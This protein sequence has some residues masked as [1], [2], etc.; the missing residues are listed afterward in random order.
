MNFSEK[1]KQNLFKATVMHV[2]SPDAVYELSGVCGGPVY[3]QLPLQPNSKQLLIDASQEGPDNIY[4]LPREHQDPLASVQCWRKV[5]QA[6]I[7]NDMPVAD[8]EKKIVEQDQRDRSKLRAEAGTLDR[9]LYFAKGP[10]DGWEFASDRSVAAYLQNPAEYLWPR[11]SGPGVP[12]PSAAPPAQASSSS[13]AAPTV[14]PRDKTPK[15]DK[16][17]A[18]ESS[19]KSGTRRKQRPTTDDD[20]PGPSKSSLAPGDTLHHSYSDSEAQNVNS[21]EDDAVPAVTPDV[22]VVPDGPDALNADGLRSRRLSVNIP[23]SA[24]IVS[25]Q[26]SPLGPSTGSSSTL[27][28]GSGASVPSTPSKHMSSRELKQEKKKVR[29]EQKIVYAKVKL[30]K[31]RNSELLASS[32]SLST[33]A[34]GW[35]KIRNSLK[36]WQAR[37]VILQPG[38]LIYFRGQS[39]VDKDTCSGIL[40][41]AGCEVRKR[42]SKK[43]GFCFKIFHLSQYPIYSK[44]G[45]KGETLKKALLPVGADY[46]IMRV[47]DEQDR[48]RWMDAIHEAIPDYDRVKQL[49]VVDSDSDSDDSDGDDEEEEPSMAAQEPSATSEVA[50]TAPMPSSITS[51]EATTLQ[52]P[53]AALSRSAG[54]DNSPEIGDLAKQMGQLYNKQ[55]RLGSHQK[56]ANAAAEELKKSFEARIAAME[57]TILFQVKQLAQQQQQRAAAAEKEA[58][59]NSGVLGVISRLKGDPILAVQLILSLLLVYAM[60]ALAYKK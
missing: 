49:A 38:R 6:I 33:I 54:V 25:P 23:S 9:G 5:Y 44:Q 26:A 51:S 8:K 45:L 60:L 27:S 21:D 48:T 41:L 20:V 14:S 34:N 58:K 59:Q 4:F 19:S 28:I 15:K 46:C 16:D 36:K 12:P 3:Y 47:N 39:E 17:R 13:S 37:Y 52:A 35:V 7:D 30:E 10:D 57:K 11:S 31:K 42:P 22:V 53:R 32:S 24:S 18:D 2:D 43:D 29:E 1:S 40:S 55:R 50:S 56:A